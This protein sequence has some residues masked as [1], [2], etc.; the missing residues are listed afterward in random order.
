M[1]LNVNNNNESYETQNLLIARPKSTLSIKNLAHDLDTLKVNAWNKIVSTNS[2]T[3]LASN[4]LY[5]FKSSNIS[6]LDRSSYSLNALDLD[7][8]SFSSFDRH[9]YYSNCSD[10]LYLIE[11]MGD[12]VD[13]NNEVKFEIASESASFSEDLNKTF[14]YSDETEESG[15][16]N[17]ISKHQHNKVIDWLR[18]S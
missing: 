1:I 10:F 11:P 13:A 9:S 14:K 12:F 18:N 17:G 6:L 7:N 4:K 3:N 2:S 15:R 16:I 5:C 8:I